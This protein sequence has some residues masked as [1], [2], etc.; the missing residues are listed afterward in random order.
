MNHHVQRIMKARDLFR[1]HL[2]TQAPVGWVFGYREMHLIFG[3]E[4]LAFTDRTFPEIL[5]PFL[6]DKWVERLN[7]RSL[8]FL[9]VPI[10]A[11]LP[12]EPQDPMTVLARQLEVTQLQVKMLAE[13]CEAQGA[14]L[15]KLE[16]ELGV[17]A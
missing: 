15:L 17:S 5:N 9:G 4:G 16:Q 6:A 10:A 8:A 11:P 2:T 13:A 7:R 12:L 14:R 1:E 3:R